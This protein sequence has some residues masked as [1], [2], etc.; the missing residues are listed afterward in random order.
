[1]IDK[2]NENIL[3]GTHESLKV[4]NWPVMKPGQQS[5]ILKMGNVKKICKAEKKIFAH[6]DELIYVFA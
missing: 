3:V 6:I 4:F 5:E 2:F 1:M